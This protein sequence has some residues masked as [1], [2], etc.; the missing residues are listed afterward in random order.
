MP[1]FGRRL[2]GAG[3]VVLNVIRA[4][5]IIGLLSVIA[6]SSVMLVKTFIVSKFFFFDACEHVVRIIMAGKFDL[7][8]DLFSFLRLTR[9]QA[10]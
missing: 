5:N 3:Y 10:S 2:L 7:Q 6:A 1:S 8:L 4:M 9:V